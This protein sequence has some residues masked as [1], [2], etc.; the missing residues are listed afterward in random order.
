MIARNVLAL[1]ILVALASS[2]CTSDPRTLLAEDDVRSRTIDALLAD[3]SMRGEVVD[4]LLTTPEQR[5]FV[6]ERV[7]NDDGSVAALIDRVL[8]S[9]RAGAV[10]TSRI[11]SDKRTTRAMIGMMMATGALGEIMSQQTAECL[12][13]GDEFA[14]GN[15]RRTMLDLKRLGRVVDDWARSTGGGYPV[16]GQFEEVERCL[17]SSLPAGSLADLSLRDAW[18]RPFVYHSDDEGTTYVLISYA[19]DG[20]YDELGRVGP[21]VSHDADIV[22]SDGEFVQWPGQIRKDS[23]R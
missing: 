12:R 20:L 11:T 14:L 22:Y 7:V 16:C 17:A 4:R 19:T 15:Q 21:T 9:D 13:L 3:P 2:A 18:G 6:F 8:E 10:M 23:I 5:S 1:L